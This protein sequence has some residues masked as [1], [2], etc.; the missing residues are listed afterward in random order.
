MV[1]LNPQP[2]AA[3]LRPG[4]RICRSDALHDGDRGVRF[5]VECRDHVEP[6]FAVRH[7]GLVTA[8]LNR[9]AH[10]FLEL[11]WQEGEFFDS[12][13]RFLVCATHDAR[14]DPA[15][16]VC[17]SGPCRGAKLIVM[18]VREADGW[19]WLTSVPSVVPQR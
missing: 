6:A 9:C 13:Q 12:E 16:G 15:T 1:R 17:V 4:D 3:T 19:V 10:R 5:Q 7:T 8:F 2:C 14:Y 11:D 18:S